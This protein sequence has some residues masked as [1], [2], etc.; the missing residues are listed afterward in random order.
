MTLKWYHSH[1]SS[2]TKD[3]S[4][5]V[6]HDF[7]KRKFKGLLHELLVPLSE[8]RCRLYAARALCEAREDREAA[9]IAFRALYRLTRTLLGRP[10]YP[11]FHWD[12]VED[13]VAKY[14]ATSQHR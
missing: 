3:Y 2:S 13:W 7:S 12:L 10:K 9:E 1:F 11:E 14:D 4:D 8:R 5:N 6:I